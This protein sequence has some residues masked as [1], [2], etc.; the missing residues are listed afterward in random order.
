MDY[1]SI[2]GVQRN[3]SQ[4]DIKSAYRRLA[5]QHHPDKGG[6]TA[7]FQKVSEA[8]DV[9]SNPHKKQLYDHGANPN[10]QQGGFGSGGFEF[11]FGDSPDDIFNQFGFGFGSRQQRRK[12]RSY[13]VTVQVA[14]E[15]VLKGKDIS[16]EIIDE[17][18]RNKIVNIQ[19]PAGIE[20]GQQIKYTGMGDNSIPNLPA[21]DLIVNITVQP[22]RVFERHGNDI[23]TE[24]HISVWDA[25]LGSRV[26]VSTLDKRDL[27]INVPPGTQPGTVLSCKEE[28]IP[29]IRTKRRGNLL[30]IIKI[31]IPKNLNKKQR[32]IIN[33]LQNDL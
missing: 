14:L 5:H 25:M 27:N 8:Y 6:D 13:N 9:L 30:V 33:R 4:Q 10:Q 24:A 11:H 19:V 16:A 7:Q 28:G 1:Y 23:V 15:D 29:N 31:D 32:K 12:N 18:G 3:A 22:H 2:L 17:S 26:K 21:G 20:N